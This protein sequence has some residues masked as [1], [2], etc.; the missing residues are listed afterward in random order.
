MN[1]LRTF[2]ILFIGLVTL[3]SCE[4][5]DICIEE[6]TPYLIIRF[7]DYDDPQ[8]YKKVVDIKVELEGVEGFYEDDETT[9]TAFTDSIAIPIKVTEDITEFK[10]TISQIDEDDNIVENEDNFILTY[11]RENLFVSRSCGFKTVYN[12]ALTDLEVDNDNWILSYEPTEDPLNI[13]NQ[14]SAHVKIFH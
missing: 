13:D 14:E 3:I 7:Y 2:F 11:T 5:D 9:I 8:F 1:L 6:T 12:D 4:R 10:L